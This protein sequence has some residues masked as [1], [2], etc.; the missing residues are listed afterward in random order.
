M[1]SGSGEWLFQSIPADSTILL[2][3]GEHKL[4]ARVSRVE[5][6]TAT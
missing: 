2:I 5:T 1:E 3:R 6:R 4:G